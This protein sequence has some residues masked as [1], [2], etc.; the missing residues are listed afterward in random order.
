MNMYCDWCRSRI[1]S[2]SCSDQIINA[3]LDMLHT[4][5]KHDLSFALS[6][7]VTEIKRLDGK[8]Y[9]PNTIRE[10]VICIQMFLHE[11]M[12]MWKLFD[13]PEFVSLRNVVDNT[14]KIRH[15][16][17]LG[18]RQSAD[19]LTMSHEDVLYQKKILGWEN[20]QQLLNT[21]IYMTGMRF[22]LRGGI[23]H[24]NLKRF[25]FNSQISFRRDSRNIDCL[26]YTEDAKQKTNQG[27]L[28]CKG[29]S[30]TV[31]VYPTDGS[32]RDA[33]A[34]VQKYVGL[35]PPGTSCKKF[36]LRPK[37]NPLPSVWYC[38]QSYGMN[39]VKS[40]VK[41]ICK[42][43]GFVGKFTNHS[44]RATCATRMYHSNIPEQIIKETTG[45]R[46]E[47]VRSYKRTSE[48]LKQ[49]AS[50]TVNC[51]AENKNVECLFDVV[52]DECHVEKPKKL[53]KVVKPET[54]ASIA[55]PPP[56]QE[57]KGFELSWKQMIKNVIKTRMEIR[58][59]M[60]PKSRLS[61]KKYKG[62]KVTID[63]NLNVN[64]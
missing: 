13:H 28:V 11:N 35:M 58:K 43:A 39:K 20:P 49:V 25:G 18:V 7:F 62:H 10:I 27:G 44:L 24:N 57:S 32:D 21:V 12:I 17:G 47:C 38:D 33:V 36:H 40:T 42:Q 23:E 9:P 55:D 37:K 31:W 41:E 1:G 14:M 2:L 54:S 64:K 26:V 34:V 15:S 48:E 61:L 50:N 56:K 60:F 46:S 29:K 53:A 51:P 45:H 52:E 3:N 4:F 5:S 22:A 6:K 63:L 30:K 16:E 19:I 8:D 59:K